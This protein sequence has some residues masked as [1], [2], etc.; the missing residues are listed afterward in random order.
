MAR[1]HATPRTY[2]EEG[3]V[4]AMPGGEEDRRVG[5]I[6][7]HLISLHPVPRL[8][9]KAMNSCRWFSTSVM[10]S[11]PFFNGM[12]L[13]AAAPAKRLTRNLI[14][15]LR[16]VLIDFLEILEG[17]QVEVPLVGKI[18]LQRSYLSSHWDR[19]YTHQ[20]LVFGDEFNSFDVSRTRRTV[21][22]SIDRDAVGHDGLIRHD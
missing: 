20:R 14:V 17:Q 1:P 8:V 12:Q 16:I 10:R 11:I 7:R 15:G 19:A 4:G 22:P 18:V 3:Q 2:F 9:R 13:I 6:A 5:A 21:R